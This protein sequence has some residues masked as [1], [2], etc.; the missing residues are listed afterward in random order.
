MSDCGYRTVKDFKKFLES[1][2]D[3]AFIWAYEDAISYSRRS[4]SSSGSSGSSFGGGHS[5]GGGASGKW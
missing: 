4:S 1:I 2:P 3:D 5:G